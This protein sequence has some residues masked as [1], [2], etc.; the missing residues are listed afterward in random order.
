MDSQISYLMKDMTNDEKI[1]FM[2]EFTTERK[3]LA[4]GVLLALFLGGFGAHKF[5]LG[6]F[7][8]GI[9]YF[10]FC[11]TFIPSL[12]GFIEALLMQGTI[13]QYN[14]LIARR[15]YENIRLRR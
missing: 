10:L 7:V 8:L 15:A 14:N 2:S 12:I 9:V 3:D 4:I 11:W 13:R 5:Y 1:M 6:Q